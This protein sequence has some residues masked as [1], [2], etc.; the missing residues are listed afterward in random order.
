MAQRIS[1]AWAAFAANGE[2]NNE[3]LPQW[4]A[5]DTDQRATMI[6][7]NDT[8]LELDPRAEFRDFWNSL[9]AEGTTF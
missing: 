8:R 2:P 3:R 6:F 7:D 9:P 5:Y 4:D 1:S